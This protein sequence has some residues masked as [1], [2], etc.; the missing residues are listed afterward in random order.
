MKLSGK[1]DAYLY[2][3]ARFDKWNG[4]TFEKALALADF[5]FDYASEENRMKI[6]GLNAMKLFRFPLG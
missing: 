6:R 2:E 4:T 1:D 3:S 5:I